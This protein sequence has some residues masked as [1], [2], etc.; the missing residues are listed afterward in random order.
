[1]LSPDPIAWLRECYK[2]LADNNPA[3]RLLP[4]SHQF[5]QLVAAVARDHPTEAATMLDWLSATQLATI[6]YLPF[7]EAP[8]L[9]VTCAK[10]FS[11]AKVQIPAEDPPRPSPPQPCSLRRTVS[12]SS[13]SNTK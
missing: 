6:S 11:G 12:L 13:S 9:D 10:E 3:Y 8:R 4:P 2:R 1:M 7:Q 5:E